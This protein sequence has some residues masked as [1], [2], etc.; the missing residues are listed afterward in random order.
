MGFSTLCFRTAAL[1]SVAIFAL[2]GCSTQSDGAAG[3]WGSAE[4]GQ[5]Q[6]VLDGSG[7]LSGT[8]GCNRLTGSWEQDGE[9]VSFGAVAS[10]MMA[11]QDVDTWL[12]GLTSARVDGDTLRVSDAAG[13]EIGTLTRASE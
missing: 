9:S 12:V 2:T 10:T 6:L 3:T 8:D 1:A 7:K 4:P 5:P 13:K 11:C